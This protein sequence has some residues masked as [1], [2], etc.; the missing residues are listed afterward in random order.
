[1]RPTYKVPTSIKRS[2][3]DHELVLSGGGISLRPLPLKVILFWVV[4]FPGN[5]SYLH[6]VFYRRCGW[7]FYCHVFHLGFDSGDFLRAIFQD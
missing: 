5:S 4:V 7:D 3:L 1:M 6:P 2:M